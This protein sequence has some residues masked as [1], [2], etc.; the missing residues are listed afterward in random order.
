MNLFVFDQSSNKIR[1]SKEFW[2]YVATVAPLTML[3]LGLWFILYRKTK[4]NRARRQNTASLEMRL[5]VH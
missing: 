2:I 4:Q 1:I 3:T 5:A